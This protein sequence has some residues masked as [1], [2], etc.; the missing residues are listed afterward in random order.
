MQRYFFHLDYLRELVS[1]PDGSE[2]PN[3]DAAKNE[4]CEAVRQIA[5]N[6]LRSKTPFTLCSIRVCDEDEKLLSEVAA[7]SVITEIIPPGFF[8]V[9]CR[10][11]LH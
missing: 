2:L 3:L 1:D 11:R 8:D 5:A 9:P 6:S 10:D 7:S 4:A